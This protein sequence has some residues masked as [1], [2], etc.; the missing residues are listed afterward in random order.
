[1]TVLDYLV[2]PIVIYLVVIHMS[3]LLVN[4]S[5]RAPSEMRRFCFMV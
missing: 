1:M 2:I 4:D 5:M 3:K